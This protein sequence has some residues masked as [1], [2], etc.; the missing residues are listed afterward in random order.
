M[1]SLTVS[2][3]KSDQFYA[4]ITGS[5]ISVSQARKN[6]ITKLIEDNTTIETLYIKECH[7]KSLNQ[8]INGLNSNTKLKSLLVG[9]INSM[10][11]EPFV[12][13]KKSLQSL[14]INSTISLYEFIS[15]LNENIS[16]TQLLV[17]LTYQHSH[18][19]YIPPFRQLIQ[20]MNTTIL[21]MTIDGFDGLDLN[22]LN[23]I[24]P[25][26]FANPNIE[27]LSIN[28]E[29]LH[30]MNKI[31][32][33]KHLQDNT[34]LE[35][36]NIKQQY[37]GSL[38]IQH[39]IDIIT[40]ILQNNKSLTNVY[41]NYRDP[42]PSYTHRSA[43]PFKFSAYLKRNKEL[44]WNHIRPILTDVII[45]FASLRL[46]NDLIPPY[47]LLEIFDWIYPNNIYTGHLKKITLIT[48]MYKSIRSIK[49][50]SR[51]SFQD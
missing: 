26:I 6:G 29:I 21:D 12:R 41:A 43:E 11:F 14:G 22:D 19:L 34:K 1:T 42:R 32:T 16:I 45:A 39:S 20:N 50:V 3:I 35:S 7:I 13:V 28:V 33:I 40:D 4:K 31:L 18:I 25:Y 24:F 15:L 49:H 38:L 46:S 8:V 10:R 23:D 2:D 47:V 27:R 17:N 51:D 44:R 36:L 5:D 48:N 30:K 37:S 9:T